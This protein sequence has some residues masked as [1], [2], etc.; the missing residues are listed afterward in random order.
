MGR[1]GK[2]P[3]KVRRDA[4]ELARRSGRPIADVARSL[5]ISEG[6]LWNWVKKARDASERAVDPDALT[7]T[8]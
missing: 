3:E 8:R 4:V 1:P 5:A 7:R 6:T 2:Y